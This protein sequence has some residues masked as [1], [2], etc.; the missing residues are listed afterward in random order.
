MLVAAGALIVAVWSLRLRPGRPAAELYD[1]FTDAARSARLWRSLNHVHEVEPRIGGI[2]VSVEGT[3][4]TDFGGITSRDVYD[5][6]GGSWHLRADLESFDC[7]H[8]EAKFRLTFDHDSDYCSFEIGRAA[9]GDGRWLYLSRKYDFAPRVESLPYDPVAHRWLRLR[10]D[11]ARGQMNW[12]VSADGTAW[13]TLQSE[14]CGLPLTRV[15]P[16]IYAGRFGDGSTRGKI[17][18]RSFNVD[19]R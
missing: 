8:T 5:F 10:H 15:A 19:P 4:G 7:D 14:D 13:T 2:E 11:A 18:Y 17:V 9:Q 6:R 16:E 12:D 3:S 1:D